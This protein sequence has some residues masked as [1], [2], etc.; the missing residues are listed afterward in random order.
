MRCTIITA[1]GYTTI[2][3]LHHIITYSTIIDEYNIDEMS[4]HASNQTK[5]LLTTSQI[6]Q[7]VNKR[8]GRDGVI[9]IIC[10]YNIIVFASFFLTG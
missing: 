2:T 3:L 1:I 8:I 9:I 6:Y 7:V 10:L 4:L 5:T